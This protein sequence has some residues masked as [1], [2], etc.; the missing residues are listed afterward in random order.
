MLWISVLAVAVAAL[1]AVVGY[2]VFRSQVDPE[3][4]VYSKH[5]ERRPSVILLVTENIGKG[6]AQDVRFASSQ[7][8]PK[9]AFGISEDKVGP[10]EPMD[11]GAIVAGI[12][13]LEPGGKR[14]FAWG[15]TAASSSILEKLAYP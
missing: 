1:S 13:F 11:E 7:P 12:P 3:V 15:N 4:I 6:A 14:V 9:H 10:F 8:L 2:C 5:D